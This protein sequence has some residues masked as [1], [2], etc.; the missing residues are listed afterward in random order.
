MRE[1]AYERGLVKRIEERFPGCMVFKTDPTRRQGIPDRLILFR[2]KW[3][4]LEVKISEEAP[5]QPN[6]EFYVAA[7]NDMSFS[8]FIYPENEAEVLDEL[9]HAFESERQT[10][11]S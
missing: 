6:Q 9:Q 7:M 8:A 11:V 5:Q 3:A 4:T 1:S 10:F 2:D